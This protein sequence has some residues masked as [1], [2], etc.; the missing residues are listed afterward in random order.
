M[1]KYSK[2]AGE[3]VEEAMHEMKE[4]KL[5]TG[6]GKKVTSKKQAVAIGLSEAKKEGAKVPGKK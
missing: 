1:A 3:K 5:K 2:K 4:G 6:T